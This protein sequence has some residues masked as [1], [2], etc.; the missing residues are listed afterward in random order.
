MRKQI[1]SRCATYYVS[2]DDPTSSQDTSR[3]PTDTIT[4]NSIPSVTYTGSSHPTPSTTDTTSSDPTQ[5]ITNAGAADSNP[6]VT[7]P[8]VSDDNNQGLSSG[9]KAGIGLGVGLGTLA[10]LGILFLLW[11]SQRAKRPTQNETVINSPCPDM[12]ELEEGG[13]YELHGATKSQPSDMA[14]SANITENLP[15]ELASDE[16]SRG[17]RTAPSELPAELVIAGDQGGHPS[18]ALQGADDQDREQSPTLVSQ[19]RISEDDQ[20]PIRSSYVVSELRDSLI[21]T[22]AGKTS[23]LIEEPSPVGFL[24]DPSVQRA[25]LNEQLE[26]LRARKRRILDLEELEREEVELERRLSEL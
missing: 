3:I 16:T 13:K 25:S 7:H 18:E 9:A 21:S 15:A 26:R 23:D 12:A 11:R 10:M 1:E 17:G 14:G 2:S 22:A 19:T 5:S 20:S 8:S 6:S 4:S 24:S